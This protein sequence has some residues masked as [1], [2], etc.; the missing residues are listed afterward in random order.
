M[1]DLPPE[2]QAPIKALLESLMKFGPQPLPAPTML[3]ATSQAQNS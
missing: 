3:A 1:R 2:K